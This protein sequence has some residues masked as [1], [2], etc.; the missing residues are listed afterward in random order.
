M[1][2]RPVASSI[3]IIIDVP[4]EGEVAKI[5]A[6]I[7]ELRAFVSRFSAN[8]SK[9]RQATS[10]ARQMEKIKLE[11]IKPS[12]RVNPYI[13][14]DVGKKLYR[15]A[16]DV[17]GLTKGYDEGPLFEKLDMKIEV[18]ERVAVIHN[19]II[20]N[21]ED[22]RDELTAAGYDFDSDTGYL[23]MRSRALHE[24]VKASYPE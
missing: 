8:A 2:G 19:G 11:E 10:R 22:L 16:L 21:H 12:S 14:F 5:K 7:A 17:E 13:R 18:G 1:I 23:W 15:L 6:E 24:Q 3:F 4:G 20:E 9:A